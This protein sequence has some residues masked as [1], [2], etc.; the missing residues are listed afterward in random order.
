ML[1]AVELSVSSYN[2]ESGIKTERT[3]LTLLALS[4]PLSTSQRGYQ[5]WEKV[6]MPLITTYPH[7][8]EKHMFYS[9]LK[10]SK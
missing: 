4:T 10:A 7:Y 8:K 9:F 2:G 6:R 3:K 1:G 5:T